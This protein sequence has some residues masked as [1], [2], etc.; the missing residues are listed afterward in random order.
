M[1]RVLA[2]GDL[3][4]GGVLLYNGDKVMVTGITRHVG[5][6]TDVKAWTLPAGLPA[7]GPAF[8]AMRAA[9]ICRRLFLDISEVEPYQPPTHEDWLALQ[10]AVRQPNG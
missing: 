1:T 3:K 2:P 6:R 5:G 4:L 7:D 9:G 10:E 8:D